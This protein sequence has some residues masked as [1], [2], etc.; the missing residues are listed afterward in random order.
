MPA[1]P[2]TRPGAADDTRYDAERD[3][4]SPSMERIMVVGT[5]CAGKTTLAQRIARTLDMPHVELDA[6]YWGPNWSECPTDEFRERVRREVKGDRWVVD[7]NYAKARDIVLSRATD[8]VWLNY[9][10][11]V[12]FWRALSRTASR[13]VSGEELFG[14]NR[15]TWGTA[16]FG[17]DSIP[18]WVIKT[19]HRR[20]RAYREFFSIGE[21]SHVRLTELRGQRD[22]EEFV[23][24]IGGG[25]S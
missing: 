6:L 4:H 8:A 18:W 5:S 24:G 11:P 1:A 9:P 22:A 7:G 14:G 23:E 10:F 3:A 13:V 25:R 16:F 19:H 2:E 20:S 15:E 12:V 21:G 17:R